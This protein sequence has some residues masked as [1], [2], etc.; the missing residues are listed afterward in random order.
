MK[1]LEEDKKYNELDKLKKLEKEGKFD[2]LDRFN[3]Y[4]IFGRIISVIISISAGL[5]GGLVIPA[6]TIGCGIG[7]ILSKYTNIDQH[8][9]MFL[10]MVALVSSFLNAP[11]TSAILVNKLCNQP[12]DSIPLSLG[13]SLISYFTYRVLRN[14]F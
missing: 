1:K 7:S 12:H 4:G 6:L 13:V 2:T 11:I 3:I 5:T 10:G 8:K 14:R 9:L